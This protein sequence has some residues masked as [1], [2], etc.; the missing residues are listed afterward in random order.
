MDADGLRGDLAIFGMRALADDGVVK[1]Q[2]T[3]F[4]VM[5][6]AVLARLTTVHLSTMPAHASGWGWGASR[7]ENFALG[8]RGILGLT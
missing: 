5:A 2:L 7:E 1:T 4:G 3:R 6:G 8:K